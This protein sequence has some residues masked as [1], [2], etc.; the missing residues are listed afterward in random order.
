[1]KLFVNRK[2]DNSGGPG[3]FVEKFIT[4][5]KKEGV[6]IQFDNYKGCDSALLLISSQG[7]IPKLKEQG[8]RVVGRTSGFYIPDY[9]NGTKGRVMTPDKLA[10]NEE[11]TREIPQYDHFIYQSHWA[12]QMYDQYL[13]KRDNDYSIIHNGVDLTRF[14]PRKKDW[15]GLRLLVVGNLRYLHSVDIP[16]KIAK[17]VRE[18]YDNV[19][20]TFVG[21][22]DPTCSKYLQKEKGKFIKCRGHIKNKDLPKIYQSHDILIHARSGDVCPN[23]V[24]E[25]LA[26]GL[27]CVVSSWG[28]TRELTNIGGKAC[29]EQN[30]WEYSEEFISRS[31][32]AVLE[33]IE[34]LDRYKKK[35]RKTAE[36][37]LSVERMI[38]F[39]MR[40]L[41]PKKK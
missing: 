35:A 37:N 7:L 23:A 31:V 32:S 20:I 5:I 17:L 12:K 36:E 33:I 26:C 4:A 10:H 8:I 18:K 34:D 21:N 13:V 24:A 22:A 15:E 1:M 16:T 19:T 41:F 2:P 38:R 25:A 27:P 6:E 29:S 3:V 30:N 40:A 11:L 9:W 39:Y 14:K 28:G